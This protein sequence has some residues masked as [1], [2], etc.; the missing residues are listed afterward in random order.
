M[1]KKIVNDQDCEITRGWK[2]PLPRKK[3]V[4]YAQHISTKQAI[5]KTCQ[6]IIIH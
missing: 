5:N 3:F 2:N 1:L 6:Y 4:A